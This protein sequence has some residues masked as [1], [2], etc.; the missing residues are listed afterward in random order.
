[1]TC[2]IFPVGELS[3]QPMAGD[4]WVASEGALTFSDEAAVGS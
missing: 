4:V 2:W 1:M 3:G